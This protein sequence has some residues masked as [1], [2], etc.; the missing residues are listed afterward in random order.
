MEQYHA[1]TGETA[2]RCAIQYPLPYWSSYPGVIVPSIVDAG[3]FELVEICPSS[4]IVTI[5][6]GEL[7]LHRAHLI[8]NSM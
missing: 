8:V 5:T 1:I 6:I 2:I 4:P 7:D 3:P